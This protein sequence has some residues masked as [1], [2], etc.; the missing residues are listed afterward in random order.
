[1]KIGGKK[2]D[3][4]PASDFIVF[5]R[6]DGDIAIRANAVMDRAEFDRLCPLPSPPKKRVKGG[7]LVDNYEDPRYEGMLKDHGRK[8]TDWMILESLCSVDRDTQE[9]VPIEWEKV[10]RQKPETWHL[11]DDELKDA[12]FSDLERK[13]INNLVLQV[14]S[15]SDARLDEARNSFLQ[16]R[17]AESEASSSPS[18]EP[19]G[20]QSGEPASDSES[21]LQESQPVGTT[22]IQ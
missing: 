7:A 13:R 4:Q 3:Y 10:V 16:P 21:D 6:K 17:E 22:S 9:D 18:S 2:V 12:G 8:Y 1:M 19:S 20:T 5:P 14:N 11:W 15:L